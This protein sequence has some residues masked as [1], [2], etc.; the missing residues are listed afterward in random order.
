M[1]LG[2]DRRF[3][4]PFALIIAVGAGVLVYRGPGWHWIRVSFGDVLAGAAVYLFAAIFWRAPW[5]RRALAVAAFTVGV[6][7]LQLA[8]LVGPDSP[9]W[10]HVLLGSTFD[11]W[12]LVAYVV[13]IAGAI[14]L[15][16]RWLAPHREAVPSE[17]SPL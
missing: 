8:R 9:Q 12:D 1:R 13:G 3:V 7:C 10:M 11:P 4:L 15:E 6:E 14:A 5:R 16:I 17:G 2:F